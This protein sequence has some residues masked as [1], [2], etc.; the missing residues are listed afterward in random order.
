MYTIHLDIYEDDG[1][2]YDAMKLGW[3]S[4]SSA[5]AE[6]DFM[7]SFA[8]MFDWISSNGYSFDICVE[9]TE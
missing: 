8:P 9:V 5:I 4:E 7:D 2:L 3:W 1:C 6:K